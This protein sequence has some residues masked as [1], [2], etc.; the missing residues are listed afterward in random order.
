MSDFQLSEP[1][2]LAR[3][4]L[5]RDELVRVDDE[6]LRSGW[7]SAALLRVDPR[8]HAAVHDGALQL[9][10]A[11]EI[12]AQ[13]PADAVLLGSGMVTDGRV[14]AG[15]SALAAGD[16]AAATDVWAV[17]VPYLP[18]PA[19]GG[20]VETVD[21]RMGGADLAPTEASM[22]A[23]AT[24]L[25]GWHAR[26]SFCAV[27]GATML[28]HAAGWA[29]RCEAHGHEEYPRTDP[30]VICLVHDGADQVLLGRQPSW[31]EGRFSVL[32]GFVE[33]G[34]SLEACVRREVCEE[35]GAT[36]SDVR[37]LGSQPWPFP[38]SIMLGFAAVADSA[39]PVVPREG[40]IA[41]AAWF[42]RDEIKAALAAG[43]WA[44]APTAEL[45]LLLPG[46]V[47]IARGM[48]E[49]WAEA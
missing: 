24:A 18:A 3:D 38:R 10:R 43:H 28:A 16:A 17:T 33:A 46:A 26:T 21:L 30:A 32:A 27:C 25:L 22:L 29:R 12:A 35:V 14:V 7:Q 41:E 47:S 5:V 2:M 40:E 34:E 8:G 6:R 39:Q 42:T 49:S 13:P 23:T 31:P 44:S 48:L 36:V 11:T 4:T 20:R 15:S 45:P 9:G 37:Y 19:G 1:P